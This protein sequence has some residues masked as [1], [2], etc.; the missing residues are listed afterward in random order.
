MISRVVRVLYVRIYTHIYIDSL[1]T[2]SVQSD[3]IL[4][5]EYITGIYKINII[6]KDC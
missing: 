3:Y 6:D 5:R 4:L 2:R 1:T